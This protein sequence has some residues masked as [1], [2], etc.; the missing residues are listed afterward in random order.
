MRHRRTLGDAGGLLDQ[1]RG[2][3]RLHHEGEGLVRERGDQVLDRHAW[4]DTLGLG[5]ERLAEF[6]DVQAALTQCWADRWGWVCFTSWHLQ[7]DKT[8]DFLCH[9]G[10]YRYEW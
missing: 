7:L 5:V 8:N 4:L 3:R 1:E 10:S 6:H 2:R 9:D